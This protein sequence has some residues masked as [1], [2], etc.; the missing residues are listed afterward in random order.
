MIVY[1]CRSNSRPKETFYSDRGGQEYMRGTVTILQEGT[2]QTLPKP[3]IK[4]ERKK[5][6][7]GKMKMGGTVKTL[8]EE[9]VQTLP[10]PM[11]LEKTENGRNS[12]DTSK[13]NET[14]KI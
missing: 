6:L 11:K 4:M 9:T 12:S 5:I 7:G 3:T 1:M 10:K 14:G 13:T 2:V 8:Q